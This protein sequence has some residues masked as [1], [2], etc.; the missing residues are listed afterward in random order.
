MYFEN[1]ISYKDFKKENID[2]I[3]GNTGAL[4]LFIGTIIITVSVVV[5]L[6]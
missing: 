6:I 1:I 5:G 2:K 4:L 3:K